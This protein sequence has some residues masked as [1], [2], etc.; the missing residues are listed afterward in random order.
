MIFIRVFGIL[1]VGFNL[2][3]ILLTSIL[4][5]AR[6]PAW[7]KAGAPK[8]VVARAM[9]RDANKAETSR[10]NAENTIILR[11][12]ASYC[13]S[14]GTQQSVDHYT[15]WRNCN[16]DARLLKLSLSGFDGVEPVD[17]RQGS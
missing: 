8:F 1:Q 2:R 15:D 12:N 10:Q 4:A 7:C 11:P 5:P 17:A 9:T 16:D 13:D 3:Q 14:I 6:D